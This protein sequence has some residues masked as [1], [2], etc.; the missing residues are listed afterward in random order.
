MDLVRL[1]WGDPPDGSFAA[2]HGLYWLAVNLTASGPVLL[3]VDDLQWCDSAS[4][5]F[6]AYLV[7]RL[8]DVP[9]LVVG[10]LRTGEAHEEE[11][12]LAELAKECLGER[13]DGM[14]GA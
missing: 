12:L 4:L 10:T 8:D 3:A 1:R 2:L 7:R 6:L 5:R 9:V 14:A 13:S 11:Q